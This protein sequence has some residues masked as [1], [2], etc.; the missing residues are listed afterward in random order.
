MQCG[1]GG[2]TGGVSGGRLLDNI[3]NGGRGA[4]NETRPC[5]L[6]IRFVFHV[7]LVCN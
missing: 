4:K 3:W 5:G 2:R 7:K 6:F 1:I